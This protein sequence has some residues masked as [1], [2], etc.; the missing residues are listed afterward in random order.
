MQALGVFYQHLA[1]ARA[2]QRKKRGGAAGVA[3]FN[4]RLARSRC[5]R[6]PATAPS[7]NDIPVT[8]RD[9]AKPDNAPWNIQGKGLRHRRFAGSPRSKDFRS[10]L[11]F[12]WRLARLGV[13]VA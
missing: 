6:A 12:Y 5:N 7:D 8:R 13:H 9:G 11:D 3:H 2:A 4:G 10:R 1:G